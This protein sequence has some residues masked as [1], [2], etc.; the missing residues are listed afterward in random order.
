MAA[1]TR[2]THSSGG[3]SRVARASSPLFLQNLAPSGGLGKG[4]GGM[5]TPGYGLHVMGDMSQ[6]LGPP[7]GN[8]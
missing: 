6:G 3:D 7:G 2:I 5:R 8:V 1:K 4:S